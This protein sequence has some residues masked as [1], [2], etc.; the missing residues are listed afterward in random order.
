MTSHS[1]L[2]RVVDVE[3]STVLLR[4]AHNGDSSTVMYTSISSANVNGPKGDDTN[5]MDHLY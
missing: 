1:P 2:P 3:G 4:A 5:G